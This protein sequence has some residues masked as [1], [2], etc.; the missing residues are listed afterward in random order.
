MGGGGGGGGWWVAYSI[1]VSDQG[2]LV[3]VFLGLGLRGLGPGLDNNI[4]CHPH[5]QDR[6][7][8]KRMLLDFLL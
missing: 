1:L 6:M 5:I 8:K 3:L 7:S 2:P 4:I